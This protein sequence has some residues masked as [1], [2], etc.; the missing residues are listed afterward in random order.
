MMVIGYV[1]VSTGD[2]DFNL[3]RDALV[4]VGASQIFQ[5]TGNGAIDKRPGLTEALSH[6]REGDC[7]V[8]WRLDR[9]GRSIR[10]LIALVEELNSRG[11]HTSVRTPSGSTPRHPLGGSSFTSWQDWR[12]WSAS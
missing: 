11:V 12:R 2:Q 3:Q 9:L 4:S 10:S 5:D 8:V 1:R 6:L 7:L